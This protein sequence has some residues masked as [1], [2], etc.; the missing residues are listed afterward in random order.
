M[1]KLDLEA[2]NAA[3]RLELEDVQTENTFLQDEL[4]TLRS[5]ETAKNL[6]ALENS[7]LRHT[8]SSLRIQN[9]TLKQDMDGMSDDMGMLEARVLELTR[10]HDND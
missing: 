1:K 5:I 3:L 6:L 10:P 9:V 4:K 8:I 2:I 7:E